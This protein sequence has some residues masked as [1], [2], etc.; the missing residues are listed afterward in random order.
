M[1]MGYCMLNLKWSENFSEQLYE[2]Q[3]CVSLRG[4]HDIRQ[5]GAYLPAICSWLNRI[6]SLVPHLGIRRLKADPDCNRNFCMI[7][8]KAAF[9]NTKFQVKIRFFFI[10]DSETPPVR[11]AV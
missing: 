6:L 9:S 8:R 11:I 3:H 2:A 5:G 1:V 7:S 4:N 10:A